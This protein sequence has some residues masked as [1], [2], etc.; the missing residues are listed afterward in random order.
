VQEGKKKKKKIRKA[1][2]T[3]SQRDRAQ[4]GEGK[5][6]G[7]NAYLNPFFFPRLFLSRKALSEERGRGKGRGGGRKMPKFPELSI[8][9]TPKVPQAEKKGK[10]K[11][12]KGTVVAQRWCH[13]FLY[14]NAKPR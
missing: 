9:G 10:K 7:R 5:R 12:K 1:F 11:K 14:P 3:S 6:E 13:T 8:M 2:S 4:D